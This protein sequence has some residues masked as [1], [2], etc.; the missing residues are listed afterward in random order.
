MTR[1]KKK[2]NK[3][4][5]LLPILGIALGLV[6]YF[7]LA[8]ETF[9]LSDK[10]QELLDENLTLEILRVDKLDEVK[11]LQL[12]IDSLHTI[13]SES[14]DEE[15]REKIQSLVGERS[16]LWVKRDPKKDMPRKKSKIRRSKAHGEVDNEVDD[17]E[18]TDNEVD[19]QE[20]EDNEVDNLEEVDNEADELLEEADNE[21]DELE[22]DDN[23]IDNLE[24]VD[25]EVDDLEETDNEV[26][27]LKE[28]ANVEAN[29]V[30]EENDI[31]KTE[32]EVVN[33]EKEKDTKDESL[34][35]AEKY[36]NEGFKHLENKDVDSA[37]TSFIESE[38]SIKG[39]ERSYEIAEV[40]FK[41]RDELKDENSEIWK[42]IEKTLLK[43]SK[44]ERKDI[45]SFILN[46]SKRSKKTN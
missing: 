29:I 35:L 20:E 19:N 8:A 44:K 17:L 18:L 16:F 24:K 11:E 28:A 26:D 12:L 25:N 21:V 2:K 40:L 3:F 27:N 5:S 22:E 7:S 6:G 31:A 14:K 13:A 39:Y 30:G 33:K 34:K 23:E 38:K 10:K 36:Y 37:I 15:T 41:N 32:T 4:T 45:N 42:E 9:S 1:K 46:L 43:D